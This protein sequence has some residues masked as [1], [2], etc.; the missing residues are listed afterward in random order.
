M[1]GTGGDELS[2]VPPMSVVGEVINGLPVVNSVTYAG[3]AYMVWDRIGNI[4]VGTLFNAEG[5]PIN[6][7]RLIDRSLTCG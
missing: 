6:H 3:F 4:W 1:V 5:Q 7:C 2:L